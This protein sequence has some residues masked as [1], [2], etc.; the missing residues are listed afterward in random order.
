[1]LIDHIL[2]LFVDAGG[3]RQQ[4]IEAELPYHIANRGL[5]DLVDGVV[6]VFDGDHGLFRI[7][8]VIIGDR[9]DID[10]DIVPGDDLLGRDLHGDDAQGDAHHLLDGNEDQRQSGTAHAGKSTEQEDHAALILPEHT[11][12]GEKIEHDDKNE[13][14]THGVIPSPPR[15][16]ATVCLVKRAA[17]RPARLAFQIEIST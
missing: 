12:R 3:V 9:R 11:Q 17:P 15:Q 4:L 10:R 2:D 14:P 6:D 7:G 5:A 13:D 1:M 16:R 8:D